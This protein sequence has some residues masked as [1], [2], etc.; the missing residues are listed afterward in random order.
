[1]IKINSLNGWQRI[2]LIWTAVWILGAIIDF[3]NQYDYYIRNKSEI[4]DAHYPVIYGI[5]FYWI[6]YLALRWIKEGF[7]NKK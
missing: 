1:M 2:G 6:I 7:K 3:I 4:I 5:A